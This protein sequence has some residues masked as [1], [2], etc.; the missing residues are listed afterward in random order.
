MPVGVAEAVG[1]E[2]GVDVGV[3]V[4]VAVPVGVGVGVC[5]RVDVGVGVPVR[6][7]VREG[8]G[9]RDGVSVTT[10]VVGVGVAGDGVSPGALVGVG[11]AVGPST[12]CRGVGVLVGGEPIVTTGTTTGVPTGATRVSCHAGGVITSGRSGWSSNS[13]CSKASRPSSG[14]TSENMLAVT[15]QARS[16]RTAIR[17][18]VRRQHNPNS[19]ISR[20]TS[21]SRRPRS[22]SPLLGG[23]LAAIPKY[24]LLRC[25]YATSSSSSAGKIILDVL[26]TPTSLSTAISPPWASTMAWARYSPTP[27][28]RTSSSGMF[29]TR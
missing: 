14:S 17:A 12:T 1:V 21:R 7:G 29:V 25:S 5:V 6:V 3:P 8:V 26:P 24:F 20:R 11:V 18:V 19:S 10:A 22:L 16:G 13:P 28:P 27:R 2:V 15:S 4:G 9:V 23:S